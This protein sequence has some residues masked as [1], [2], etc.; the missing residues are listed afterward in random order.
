M[1][2]LSREQFVTASDL[3]EEEVDLPSIG[4]SVLVTG[5]SA[6]YA[7]EAQSEA[8]EMVNDGNRQVARVNTKKLETLQVYHGLVDPKLNSELEAEQFMKNC[9]PAARAVI[10]KIDE[11]SA[12]DKEA[13]SKAEA[14][15]SE[16][17]G[18]AETESVD[19][20]VV[21]RGEPA[22]TGSPA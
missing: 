14:K 8:L 19:S 2:R 20:D 1:S 22:S 9:G 6:A 21:D 13:I 15:F 18:S 4:G 11:L 10:D 3:R 16:G 5:L 17:E 12:I 7:N